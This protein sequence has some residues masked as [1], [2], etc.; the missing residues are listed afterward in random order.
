MRR[1]FGC[2]SL[3]QCGAHE[4][5]LLLLLREMCLASPI[6]RGAGLVFSVA[7]SVN[8]ELVSKVYTMVG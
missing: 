3:S 7:F 1:V 5:G 6:L 2:R 4:G 8:G